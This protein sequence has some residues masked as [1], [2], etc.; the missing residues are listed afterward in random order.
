MRKPAVVAA[1]LTVA[2]AAV[3]LAAPAVAGIHFQSTNR[4]EAQQ[5]KSNVTAEGWVEGDSAKIV[6]TRSDNPMLV[7]GGYLLT[8]DGGKT[9]VLV[10]PEEKTYTDFDPAQLLA[11]AGAMMKAM[12]PMVKM[13]FSNPKVEKLAEQPGEA[14]H[15]YPTTHYRF[16]TTY[17]SD[18]R[19]MGM[20]QK[21]SNDTVTDT[22]TTTALSDGGF[23]AYL[24]RDPPR[25]GIADLDALIDAEIGKGITGVPLKMVAVTTS[26]DQKGRAT[27]STTTMEV[28]SLREEAVPA[29]TFQLPGGYEKVELTT[30][31][32]FGQ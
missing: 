3:G 18:I 19:V 12:G 22:W 32:P 4:T 11:A 6:F 21:A 7:E 20:G 29:T 25:T 30:T 9:V 13:S 24:R 26:T 28:T 16:R 1:T 23:G 5:G 2:L 27:T 8:T 31:L 17:D 15:G 14:M 10:N